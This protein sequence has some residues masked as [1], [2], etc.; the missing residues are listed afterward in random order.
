MAQPEFL[1][2]E[3]EL[4]WHESVLKE[5]AK[6][7]YKRIVRQIARGRKPDMIDRILLRLAGRGVGKPTKKLKS[8]K[9]G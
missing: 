4:E 1:S 8:A 5:I 6:V 2:E 7:E 3:E 9:A